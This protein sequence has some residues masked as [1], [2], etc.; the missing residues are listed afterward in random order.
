MRRRLP[1]RFF[2]AIP[3]R[4]GGVVFDLV[5][6]VL[7]RLKGGSLPGW[8]GVAEADSL[9]RPVGMPQRQVCGPCPV[10]GFLPDSGP[11]VPA[12]AID[13]VQVEKLVGTIVEGTHGVL[14]DRSSSAPTSRAIAVLPRCG[15]PFVLLRA[16]GQ[17]GP[18]A[19]DV[20]RIGVSGPC[21][22][23]SQRRR[24]ALSKGSVR[25]AARSIC[26]TTISRRWPAS[27]GVF[28]SSAS[29]SSECATGNRRSGSTGAGARGARGRAGGGG[30]GGARGRRGGGPFA[31][32]P[33]RFTRT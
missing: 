19:G 27:A 11:K 5:R 4:A 29:I 1:C 21:H 17:R 23:R 2:F 13:P 3:A 31:S 15:R 10:P 33:A 9:P 25:Q 6:A 22:L 12:R 18:I 8:L 16:R 26:A 24:P 30:G 20:D 7:P 14:S 32:R 28:A